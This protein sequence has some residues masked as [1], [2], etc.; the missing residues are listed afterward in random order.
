M[1]ASTGVFVKA[2]AMTSLTTG[3]S[4]IPSGWNFV[5]D[6]DYLTLTAL[7]NGEITIT[8]PDVITTAQASSLSYSKDKSKW[9]DTIIDPAYSARHIQWPISYDYQRKAHPLSVKYRAADVRRALLLPSH[10]HLSADWQIIFAVNFVI[11]C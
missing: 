2:P 10:N 4:G 11:F 3:T 7:S 6:S 5:D 9:T 8:I 1:L